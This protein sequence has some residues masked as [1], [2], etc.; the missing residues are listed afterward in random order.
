[1][2]RL[3]R[4]FRLKPGDRLHKLVKIYFGRRYVDYFGQ[5]DARRISLFSFW[6]EDFLIR[7]KIDENENCIQKNRRTSTL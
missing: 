2:G 1:M 4:S 6:K 3:I 7:R 5:L